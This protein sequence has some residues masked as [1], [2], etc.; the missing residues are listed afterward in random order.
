MKQILMIREYP[1]HIGIAIQNTLKDN[2]TLTGEFVNGEIVW[3]LQAYNKT[4]AQIDLLK[5]AVSEYI[6]L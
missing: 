1:E 3:C 4:N 5:I 2:Y 6:I